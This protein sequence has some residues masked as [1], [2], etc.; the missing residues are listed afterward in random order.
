VSVG[1][2]EEMARFLESFDR[3]HGRLAA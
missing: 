3:V 1:L 2:A